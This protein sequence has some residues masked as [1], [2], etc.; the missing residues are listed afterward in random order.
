MNDKKVTHSAWGGSTETA[1]L[2]ECHPGQCHQNGGDIASIASL[3][4]FLAGTGGDSRLQH[5]LQRLNSVSEHSSVSVL[6][7]R[8]LGQPCPA[9]L[10][11]TSSSLS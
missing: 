8:E 5:M 3:L 7:V 1:M 6:R 4:H 10:E 11:H 2:G 9:G